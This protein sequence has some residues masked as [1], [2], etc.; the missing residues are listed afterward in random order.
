MSSGQDRVGVPKVTQLSRAGPPAAGITCPFLLA[1]CP[2]LPPLKE[3]F[4]LQDLTW[5]D[6]SWW[7]FLSPSE[8]A[9][10]TLLRS[11]N[12]FSMLIVGTSLPCFVF[13]FPLLLSSTRLQM[14]NRR[15]P[16]H[17][18][19]TLGRQKVLV[20]CSLNEWMETL[21]ALGFLSINHFYKFILFRSRESIGE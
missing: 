17:C 11:P 13:I 1:D 8:S 3:T 12:L 19:P 4:I 6:L 2:N 9:G 15:D 18:S 10:I 20:I 7:G 14:S 5:M 16:A 21:S